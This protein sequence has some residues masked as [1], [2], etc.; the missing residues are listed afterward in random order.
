[1]KTQS[2]RWFEDYCSAHAVACERIA[3]E[4]GRTPDYELTMDGQRLVV[5]VK[6]ISLNK[7][8]RESARLV[9]ER[10]YGIVLSP[11]PGNR[12][13]KKIGDSSAQIK[14]RTCGVYPSMLVL[15]ELKGGCGQVGGHLD[16]Y[17]I[18]VAMYGLE[19]VHVVVPSDRDQT[20]YAAG[21]SYG[22]KRKMTEEDN[23]SISAIGVLSTP[24]AS[25]IVLHVYHN[26]HA[27]VPLDSRLLASRGIA[28]FR[29]EDD[30]P[31]NTA[32]WEELVVQTQP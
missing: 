16:S 5:E 14:A 8:E 17:N 30:V 18:R 1:M 25:E 7:E 21:M 32:K 10:G 27:T 19:Q 4:D 20:A 15:C 24:K 22:P 13:R 23:T 6:E 9:S 11:T 31:L 3:E 2:E 28:Q 12:V 29:L 26:K